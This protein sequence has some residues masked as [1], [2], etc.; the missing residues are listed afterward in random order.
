M[1]KTRS[2]LPARI[3]FHYGPSRRPQSRPRRSIVCR[4]RHRTADARRGWPAALVLVFLFTAALAPRLPA[5]D[6]HRAQ[7]ELAGEVTATTAL[8]QTRLTAI[9][10]P[11]LDPRGDIPGAAGL[12]RFAYRVV[13]KNETAPAD[14]TENATQDAPSWQ[15]TDWL[16]AVPER[17]FIVRAR[18]SELQPDTLYQY[19]VEATR[20]P[21]DAQRPEQTDGIRRGPPRSFRTLG[22]A[23]RT[24]RLTFC[25]GSCMHYHAFMSGQANGGGPVTAT[26]EDKR[27]GYPVFAAMRNAEPEFFIGTGD[28][29]YY[30]HPRNRRARTRPELLRKWHEQ[31]RFP[32]LIDFFAVTPA[33]WSK[34]DHDFRFND[35]DLLGD[36]K[37]SAATGIDLFRLQLPIVPSG[38]RRLPTYRTYR[39]HRHLQIWLVEGRDYRS[40]NRM[41]DGPEKSIW[42]DEQRRWLQETLAASDATW[43]VIVSPT[44]MVGPDRASK[45]DNHTNPRG[46]RHE[47]ESFMR[48]LNEEQLQRV[49]V[50]CGDRH[51]Q[52]HSIHPSGLEEFG[53]GALNDENA[54]RGVRPGAK[55][56][57]DPQGQ[58]DQRYLY[59]RPSG[60]FLQATVEQVDD[61]A[62]LRVA[63]KDDHGEIGYEAVRRVPVRD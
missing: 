26:E 44:P 43:K 61:Q 21:T 62:V 49:I 30:D 8:V 24:D 38:N 11:Q 59:P 13:P 52:Y 32:R 54:I 7:G 63:L 41:R 37:P 19:R 58:I 50:F 18:L 1:S 28:I 42:G 53:C 10:G 14:Q 57:T 34:D 15:R 12:V 45:R 23:D 2:K 22:G 17:D 3:S 5:A 36:Q 27:L 25:M 40:P 29:V 31:F 33:Y 46:F 4:R 16:P 39:V 9:A 60:G 35:A 55:G 47:G 48:W 20:L 6:L 51:W 56:S